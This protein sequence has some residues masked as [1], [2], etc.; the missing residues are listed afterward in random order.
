[1]KLKDLYEQPQENKTGT[2]AGVRFDT[3]TNRAL[4]EYTR[5]NK[6][7]NSVRPD[8][9]HSTVL[10]SRKH[11]PEYKPAGKL[12][13]TLKGN[14]KGFT[15]WKTNASA[16]AE[17]NAP[18]S[19]ALI[20]LYDSPELVERH[21]ALMKEHDATYDFPEYIPH[22]TMSY[23]IGDMDIKELP[24]VSELGPLN[25]VEEY[26]EDLDLDWARNKGTS[27]GG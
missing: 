15:V 8:K 16:A 5:T 2:Y 23:D 10:Y 6:I 12:E 17:N 26:G 3:D 9:F 22:V 20:L 19:N 18:Q 11:L 13:P 24:D 1:M 27:K 7:P 4:H 21:K 25:I 14:P